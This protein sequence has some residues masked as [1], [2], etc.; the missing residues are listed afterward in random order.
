MISKLLGWV[1]R[2]APWAIVAGLGYAAAF[3]QPTVEPLPLPQPLVE[4]RDHF[5]DVAGD[6]HGALWFAGNAGTVLHRDADGHWARR[7]FEQP[8]NL[9]G[10]AEGDGRVVAVGNQGWVFTDAGQGWSALQLPVSDYAGKLIAVGYLNGAFWITGEMGAIFRGDGAGDWQALSLDTDVALNDITRADDG[11]LWIAAEFGNLFHSS[12]QGRT[13]Q[14]QELQGESLQ[15]IAFH[16]PTGVAV[17]N[18]GRVYLSDDTGVSWRAVDSGT[19]EHLYDVVHD[20]HR[21]LAVGA[22]GVLLTSARGHHWSPLAARGFSNG[23]H[24]RALPTAEGLVV[25]GEDLGR[26]H[27]G[28]WTAWPAEEKE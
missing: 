25:T 19:H 20:G 1:A 27:Q 5:L 16:G 22:G 28:Q 15:A 13:W 17:G 4:P 6:G 7:A 18:Q 12:D 10:I 14:R 24:T 11:G 3:V 23:Y 26:V 21:W 8:V 9:Q 2:I